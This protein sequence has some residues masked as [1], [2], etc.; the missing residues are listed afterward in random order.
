MSLSRAT[1]M[2]V[3]T[4][5][6]DGYNSHSKTGKATAFLAEGHLPRKKGRVH[7]HFQGLP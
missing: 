3:S 2:N 4:A 1:V 7:V 5:V 6:C